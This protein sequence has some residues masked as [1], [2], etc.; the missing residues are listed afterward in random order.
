M[1]PVVCLIA[2]RSRCGGEDALVR[3]VAAASLAGVPLVQIR[4]HDLDAAALHRVVSRCLA[5]VDRART[6]VLVNDRLDVALAAGA[7]G[8][9]LRGASFPASRVREIVAPSFVIGRSVRTV[10]EARSA[11]VSAG[12]DY[13]V[14]GTVFP[15]RSKPGLRSAGVEALRD[16][17]A[18]SRVPV[19]AV[20]GV[21]MATA[22]AVAEAGAAG[23]AAI[24][25]FSTCPETDIADVVASVLTAFDGASPAP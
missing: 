6:R 12:L 5:A 21:G 8:V 9:H 22:R 23:L 17:V 15:S 20:G 24:D 19:L 10:D 3:R 2:D 16:V 11:D 25:L 4:E 18:A 14:F 7:D 13:L 1:R